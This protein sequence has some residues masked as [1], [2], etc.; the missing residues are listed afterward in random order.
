MRKKGPS[1]NFQNEKTVELKKIKTKVK[2]RNK[3]GRKN[4]TTTM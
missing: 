2:H 1:K 3:M 4:T